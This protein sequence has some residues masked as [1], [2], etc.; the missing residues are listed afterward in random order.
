MK[1]N[2]YETRAFL[3]NI[4]LFIHTILDLTR[5]ANKWDWGFSELE[6]KD[7]EKEGEK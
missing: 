6:L 4:N 7:N 2:E 3:Y 5:K 1:I